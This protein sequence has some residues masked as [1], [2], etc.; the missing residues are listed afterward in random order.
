MLTYT[1]FAQCKIFLEETL[2]WGGDLKNEVSIVVDN[3]KTTKNMHKKIKFGIILIPCWIKE[4]E[5]HLIHSLALRDDFS[6]IA[7]SNSKAS[8]YA[9]SYNPAENA[10]VVTSRASNIENSNY[11]LYQI[12]KTTDSS[13]PDGEC[14]YW[15]V[16]RTACSVACQPGVGNHFFK[17]SHSATP[18]SI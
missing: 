10:V 18:S 17:K 9:L 11:D 8:I 12:P 3:K 13:S 5:F 14:C 2:L 6:A 16:W 7:S 4:F 1:T 15:F